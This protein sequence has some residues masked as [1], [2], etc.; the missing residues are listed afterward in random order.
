MILQM[1]FVHVY[2]VYLA[3]VVSLVEETNTEIVRPFRW[4]E[5]CTRSRPS[6]PVHCIY[7]PA[8][9]ESFVKKKGKKEQIERV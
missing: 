6:I 7:H 5:S 4:P 3:E 1:F 9:P 8:Q 2:I